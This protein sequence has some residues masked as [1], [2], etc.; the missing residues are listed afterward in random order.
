[1]KVIKTVPFQTSM[2][3][4]TTA[5]ES[6][7][8]WVVGTTYA[9]DAEVNYANS[10]YVSLQSSNSGKQPDI[11]P[12]WWIRKSANNTYSMFD[13]FVNS[14]TVQSSPLQV[15]IKPGTGI[16]SLAFFNI[17]NVTEIHI[18]VKDSPSGTIVYDKTINL[19][20]TVIVDWYG[21]F[22]E[23]YDLKTDVIF[24]DIP[25]Y[26]D[27][28]VNATFTGASSVAVGSTVFG[29]IY[30]IGKTQY[31][32]TF[33][34]RDYSVKTTNAFGITTFTQRAFSKRME[35]NVYVD[36]TNLR[37]VQK[38]LQDLRAIPSVWIGSDAEGFD[39]L[40]IYGYYRDFN[41]EIPYPNNSFCRLEIEGLI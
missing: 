1:M 6:V 41:V 11:E 34:I 38:L 13:G 15:E 3:T 35:A 37:F 28:V 7:A 5:T 22:F 26:H 17:S 30:Q 39:V 36:N 40:S 14:Q 32:A 27:C 19:D 2:L 8:N 29:N 25:P 4:S 23:P 24:Q 16:N 20:D 12:T 18:V 10:I 21:Y 9:K 31:G 33:G